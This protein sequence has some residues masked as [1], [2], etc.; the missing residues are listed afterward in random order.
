M[1]ST[2]ILERKTVVAIGAAALIFAI[3]H[4]QSPLYFSNQH[5]YFLHGLASAGVGYLDHDWLA[6]TRDPTP[7]FSA[8][9]EF[10]ARHLHVFVFHI[11]FI[12]LMATYFLS[13]LAIGRLLL[14]AE[15]NAYRQAV[16]IV[17]TAL[18][19]IHAGIVRLASV[20]L[21]G[22]DYPWYL[23]CG[24]ANQYVVGPGLQPSAFGV[25]L[26]ASIAAFAYDRLWLAIACASIACFM[27]ATYLLPCAMITLGYMFELARVGRN[28]SALFVGT[29]LL[30]LVSPV[31]YYS[32]VSFS[33]TSPE[34][35]ET[36]ERILAEFRIP[37]HTMVSRW[38]DVIALLQTAWIIFAIYLVRGTKLFSVLAIAFVLSVGGTLCQWL[39]GNVTLSL[40]FPWRTSAVLMPIA[41]VV[42]V[43]RLAA[44]LPDSR[45]LTYICIGALAAA[46]IGGLAIQFGKLAYGTNDEELPTL[47][48]IRDHK[49]A[50]D[51]YLIPFRVPAA[52]KEAR[53]SP[54]TTF[55][56]PP[57]SNQSQLIAVDLQR[58]RLYTA[59]PLYIDFKSVPYRDTDVL[60]WHRRVGNC[61]KWYAQKDW[62]DRTLQDQIRR[63]GITHVLMPSD[64]TIDG[65]GFTLVYDVGPFRIYRIDR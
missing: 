14:P 42:I 16:L 24:V 11:I 18:V 48:F 60:E 36:A 37:H 51:V 4:T 20:H 62:G 28:R 41:T 30:V 6:T 59:A 43:S 9:V 45:C 35:F 53:S 13:L 17:I 27:H 54:S 47:D 46:T 50:G 23:Q 58:F 7:L 61:Q 34:V 40:M 39:T 26:V 21:F 55:T 8:M 56:P 3:A 22:L 15:K 64:R 44:L 1:P 32:L 2:F 65:P 52:A 57:R 19:V 5:Q 29:A 38:C 10:S 49:Q 25:F 33:P 63:E 31:V 12:V